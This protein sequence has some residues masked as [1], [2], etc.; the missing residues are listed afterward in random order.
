MISYRYNARP[1][2]TPP[3]TKHRPAPPEPETGKWGGMVWTAE[4]DKLI[5]HEYV[6]NNLTAREISLKLKGR[7]RHAVI[8]RLNRLGL[9][10]DGQMKLSKGFRPHG[11]TKQRGSNVC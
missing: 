1:L 11:N 10:L 5:R 4:E 7:S 6:V 8:G 3:E 9:G 2:S